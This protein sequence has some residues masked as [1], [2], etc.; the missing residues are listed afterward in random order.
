MSIETEFKVGEKVHYVPP[1]GKIEN[2]IVKE[3]RDEICFVVY[4][5]DNDWKN[6]KDYTAASTYKRNLEKGWIN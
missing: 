6:Y 1:Y 4:N 5:C 3:V 2:G